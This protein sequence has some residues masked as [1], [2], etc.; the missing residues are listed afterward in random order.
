MC[1]IISGMVVGCKEMVVESLTN[2]VMKKRN[3]DEILWYQYSSW[4]M[5]LVK[6]PVMTTK[7]L[8]C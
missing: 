7:I 6:V 5:I 1:S 3:F 2:L 8:F 4:F